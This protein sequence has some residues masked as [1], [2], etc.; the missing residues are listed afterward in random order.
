MEE[1]ENPKPWFIT[2]D[3]ERSGPYLM[4]ELKA[5]A[6]LHELKPRKPRKNVRP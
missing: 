4:D 6:G 5:K 1:S 3:G 2:H